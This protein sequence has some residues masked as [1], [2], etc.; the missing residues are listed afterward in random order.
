M[1][2][3]SK[4]ARLRC[5]CDNGKETSNSIKEQLIP[6]PTKWLPD[7]QAELCSFERSHVSI[8]YINS[9]LTFAP[10]NRRIKDLCNDG[11][12][13]IFHFTRVIGNLSLKLRMIKS[14]IAMLVLFAEVQEKGESGDYIVLEFVRKNWGTSG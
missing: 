12:F 5:S 8:L 4:W 6:W 14:S 1:W 2:T 10:A 11:I 7:C 3:W 13:N 9:S